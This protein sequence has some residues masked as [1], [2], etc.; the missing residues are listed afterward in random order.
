MGGVDL[1]DNAVANY[2][3]GIR[4][5]KW[6]W[7]LWVTC[8]DSASV[9]AWKLHCMVAEKTK[10]KPMSQIDFKNSITKTLLLSEEPATNTEITSSDEENG[11]DDEF[12]DGQTLLPK[13]KGLHMSVSVKHCYRRCK[14]CKKHTA[15]TCAKCN[16]NLHVG[17]CFKAY[18]KNIK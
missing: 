16:V 4:G 7:P 6:W 13:N 8:L 12:I 10:Q 15:F 1:H 5:K 2:R 18:H 11:S 9:N 17:N 14:I 3:I